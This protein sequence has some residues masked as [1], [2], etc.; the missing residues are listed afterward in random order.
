M[1]PFCIILSIALF[2]TSAAVTGI[3]LDPTAVDTLTHSSGILLFLVGQLDHHVQAA[4]AP[5][6]GDVFFLAHPDRSFFQQ[7]QHVDSAGVEEP[8]LG[9]LGIIG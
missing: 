4:L 8:T 6:L 2:N 7:V 5:C 3:T 1:S 9:A